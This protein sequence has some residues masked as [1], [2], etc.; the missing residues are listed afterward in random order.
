MTRALLPALRVV[1]AFDFAADLLVW[2]D[3]WVN[4]EPAIF[5]LTA[6]SPTRALR[7][8][9]APGLRRAFVVVRF[10]PTVAI[11]SSSFCEKNVRALPG[12]FFEQ[13]V[14][15][16]SCTTEQQHIAVVVAAITLCEIVCFV[17]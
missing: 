17:C 11:R 12:L 5:I 1:S 3:D 6:D 2:Q 8:F 10:F 7:F 16:Q 4:V 15:Q 9:V 13:H 14:P